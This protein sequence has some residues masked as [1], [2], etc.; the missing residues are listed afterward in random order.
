[1]FQ[2]FI[3][4]CTCCM[5]VHACFKCIFKC[6]ICLQMY[7]AYVSSRYFKSRS[8]VAR[9]W[10]LAESGLPQGFGSYL[11]QPRPLSPPFPSLHLTVAV[12]ARPER[13]GHRARELCAW[14]TSAGA[15]SV[16]MPPLEQDGRG[17][18]GATG[19]AVG[20]GV[21]VRASGRTSGR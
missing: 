14:G 1:M 17:A 13:D 7:V 16:R 10:W 5:A 18:E 20:N 6:F 2:K 21:Q 4:C 19:I 12:Q 3:W 15:L 11:A 9:R 8:G